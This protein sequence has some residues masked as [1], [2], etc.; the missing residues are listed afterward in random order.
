MS[1]R[2]AREGMHMFSVLHQTQ[3]PDQLDLEYGEVAGPTRHLRLHGA[4]SKSSCSVSF[5]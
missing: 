2:Y 1:Q 3:P 5:L 4:I